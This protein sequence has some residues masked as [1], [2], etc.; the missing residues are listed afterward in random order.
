MTSEKAG[1]APAFLLRCS[2]RVHHRFQLLG[3]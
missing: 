2:R 1:L 3:I